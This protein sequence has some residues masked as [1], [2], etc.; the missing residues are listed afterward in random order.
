MLPSVLASCRPPGSTIAAARARLELVERRGSPCYRCIANLA[1][2]G[3]PARCGFLERARVGFGPE[4]A[5]I[6]TPDPDGFGL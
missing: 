2:R 6:S 4:R 5:P 1:P 3:G